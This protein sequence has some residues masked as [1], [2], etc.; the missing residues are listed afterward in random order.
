MG[1]PKSWTAPQPL[2][3]MIDLFPEIGIVLTHFHIGSISDKSVQFSLAEK[4]NEKENAWY[5]FRLCTVHFHA[6]S[7]TQRW[8][9]FC[10][11]HTKVSSACVFCADPIYDYGMGTIPQSTYTYIDRLANKLPKPFSNCKGQSKRRIHVEPVLT[12]AFN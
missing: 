12:R 10:Q 7:I 3:R 8:M 4:K 9:R 6:N 1:W 5:A 11:K 2:Y